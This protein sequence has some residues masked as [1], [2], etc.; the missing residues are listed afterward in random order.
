[1]ETDWK[2]FEFISEASPES[3]LLA[4]TLLLRAALKGGGE[5]QILIDL[6]RQVYQFLPPDTF[7]SIFSDLLLER[8]PGIESRLQIR[9]VDDA[10][11][12][13]G[14]LASDDR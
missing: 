4:F 14:R 3:K 8:D 7:R 2:R 12:G 11:F 6:P 13:Y 9:V 5:D 1:M 10:A